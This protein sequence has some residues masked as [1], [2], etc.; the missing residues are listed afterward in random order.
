MLV[1][2]QQGGK[3]MPVTNGLSFFFHRS[4][5]KQVGL[6]LDEKFSLIRKFSTVIN[7]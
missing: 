6:K 2:L 7:A 4:R 1:S 5:A 3:P